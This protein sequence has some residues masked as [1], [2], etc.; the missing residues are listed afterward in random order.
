MIKGKLFKQQPIPSKPVVGIAGMLTADGNDLKWWNDCT[1]VNGKVLAEL[2][3]AE[4]QAASSHGI[5]FRGYE[6]AATDKHGREVLK[7]QEWWITP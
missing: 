7:Y 5:L 3:K 4:I 2:R 6:P 1:S